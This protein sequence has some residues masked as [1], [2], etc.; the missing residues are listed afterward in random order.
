[1]MAVPR[2]SPADKPDLQLFLTAFAKDDS[3]A[4]PQE[5]GLS[6]LVDKTPAQVKAV[7]SVKDDPLLF[8]VLVDISKSAA[9]DANSVKEAAFQVFQHLASAPNEGYLVLFNERVA[10]SRDPI[11]VAQAKKALDSARFEG[12]TAVYDAIEATCKQ[13]L[14]R[15]GNPT[16]ARRVILLISDGEDNQSHVWRARAEEAALEEGV[17]V[18]SLVISVPLSSFPRGRDNGPRGELFLREVSQRTGGVSTDKPLKKA[19]AFSLAAVDAQWMITL[20]PTQTAD[21]KLHSIQV[22]SMQKGVQIYAPTAVQLE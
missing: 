6:V 2:Q 20:A 18:F 5:T 12:G 15:S 11:S 4:V 16:R 14:S 8:A 17:S 3:P 13:V 21:N 7:R 22:K 19:V 10:V 9:T 1:M